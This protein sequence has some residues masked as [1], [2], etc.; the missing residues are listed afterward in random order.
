MK[1]YVAPAGIIAVLCLSVMAFLATCPTREPLVDSRVHN[2]VCIEEERERTE[3]FLDANDNSYRQS[4]ARAR[5][6]LDSLDVDPA[7][8][9][10]AGIKGKKKL[11]ELLDSYVRLYA[12]AA[13]QQEKRAIMER[14][15]EV[16]A[17]TYTSEYH[18]MLDLNDRE[19]KQ[20][21][22]SY[23]RA[24]LLMEELGLET[25]LYRREIRKVHGRLNEHMSVRGPHQ[26]LVFHWYYD[27]FGLEEPFDLSKAIER[28]VIASRLSPYKYRNIMKV[29]ELTH[30]IFVPYQ[31]GEKLDADPF[32][33]GELA[34]LRRTLDV[35]TSYYI[36]R[37]NSDITAELVSCVRYVKMT[38]LPVYREGLS[39]LLSA[40]NSNGTWGDY[41]RS[42]KRYGDLV[43]QALYLHTTA[44]AIDALTNAF[45][46]RDLDGVS[47]ET[48]GDEVPH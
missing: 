32:D 27:H 8:L 28:G 39:Y 35:L 3:R 24:A 6:W 47:S 14:I 37:R 33:S 16:V 9:R 38:D 23:L 18:D 1:K 45:Y 29:Y 36:K 10:A 44:V 43:D 20:D 5:R 34:Y 21:A 31:Y 40:Q 4:I 12:I 19:F 46:F 30:E 2:C 11:V 42:R 41:E 17:V 13:N 26:R 25:T 15:R 7:A 48:R 22:T